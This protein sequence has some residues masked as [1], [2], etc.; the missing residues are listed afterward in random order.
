MND[1]YLDFDRLDA[2]DAS[3]FQQQQPFP[4]VN[5]EGVLTDDGYER[6]LGSL[7][8]VSMFDADFGRERKFGQECH[9]RYNLEY[10]EDL[11]LARE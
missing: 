7:P 4:F 6:L 11:D 5:P 2:I 1:R 3:A 10:R 8:D 9:D